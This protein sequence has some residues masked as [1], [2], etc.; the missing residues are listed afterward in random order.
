M[1][2]RWGFDSRAILYDSYGKGL[3]GVDR[4]PVGSG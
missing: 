4:A 3:D 1:D 2:D